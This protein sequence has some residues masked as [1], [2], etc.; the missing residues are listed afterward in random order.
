[1]LYWKVSGWLRHMASGMV[2]W[3]VIIRICSFNPFFT[4]LWYYP[5]CRKCLHWQ[6]CFLYNLILYW[7]LMCLLLVPWSGMIKHWRSIQELLMIRHW[8]LW[9]YVSTF[10]VLK[11]NKFNGKIHSRASVYIH[12]PPTNYTALSGYKDDIFWVEGSSYDKKCH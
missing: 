2:L 3:T 12:F 10:L 11:K 5:V 7:T 6:N 1:M 9:K 4:I 8:N